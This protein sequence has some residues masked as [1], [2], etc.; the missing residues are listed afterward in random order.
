M[1]DQV[2][3]SSASGS[4]ATGD[5][6]AARGSLRFI[7]ERIGAA[8]P[9]RKQL[10]KVFP[11]NW[12]F[13]MGE[14]ALYSFVVLLLT[15]TYLSF[16]FDP[17]MVDVAYHGRYTLLDGLS[18]SRAYESTLHVSFDVRGGLMIRQL[19]HWAALMFVAAMLVH[20]LRVFF[21]GAF[22]KPRDINWVIGLSML[23]CGVIEGFAG[24]SLP[25]DLLSGTGLRIADAIILSIPV[26][27]TWASFLLFGAEYPG[28]E[29]I[30]RLYIAHVLLLPGL[31]AALVAA[32]L[33]LVVK[34]KHTE[35][36]GAGRTE[37]TVSGDRLYPVYAAK[38]GGFFFL[39]FGTLAALSGMVQINPIWLY[40]PY[41]PAKVSSDSQP[42]WYM[43]LPEGLLRLMP[44]WELHLFGHDVPPIFWAAVVAPTA[45]ILLAFAYPFI[46]ARLTGDRAHHHLLQRPRDAPVRTSLG[47][48]GLSFCV[49]LF[50]AGGDDVLAKTFDVPLGLLV[51]A[52]RVG[53]F[54]VPPIAYCISYLLCLGLQQGDRAVLVH[55][56]ATGSLRRLPDGRIVEDHQPLGP[57]D[58]HGDSVLTYA[59]APV[60]KSMNRV[61]RPSRARLR[62][63]FA[64]VKE[65]NPQQEHAGKHR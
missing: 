37:S 13:M 44:P 62:G 20:M 55:G 35:F 7:D 53:L 9:L 45:L 2:H 23:I 54:I 34:Q 28:T 24:Y 52:G 63:F 64:P 57:L 26:V 4:S 38:A 29:I 15:G 43:G 39:V 21:T 11:D 1:V 40:G 31:I 22:R 59:G 10:N 16:F 12:S 56:I 19:H 3:H 65:P 60:P 61:L 30:G 8:A 27:G 42:D 48:M 47:F 33:A 50:L 58:D 36:P 51:W 49:I 41:D 5:N 18:M 46:E 32:H 6:G 17:S 25:D 14:I